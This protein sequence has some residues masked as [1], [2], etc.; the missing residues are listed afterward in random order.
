MCLRT[1]TKYRPT[2]GPLCVRTN[3]RTIVVITC[4]MHA[5]MKR[6]TCMGII[7]ETI[8]LQRLIDQGYRSIIIMMIMLMLKVKIIELNNNSNEVL[9]QESKYIEDSY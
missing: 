7:E 8:K 9:M 6:K 1:I 5:L 4:Y 2:A 3:D